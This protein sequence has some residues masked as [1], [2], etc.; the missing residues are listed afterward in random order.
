MHGV[1]VFTGYKFP[2]EVIVF[3]RDDK[4]TNSVDIGEKTEEEYGLR[5]RGYELLCI[6]LLGDR[7][8]PRAPL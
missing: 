4:A 1:S 2:L 3:G 7:V 5:V 6:W 8:A